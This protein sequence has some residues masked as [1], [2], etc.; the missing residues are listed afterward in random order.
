MHSKAHW[1]YNTPLAH[2][3]LHNEKIDENSIPS[4]EN[5]IINN[6]GIELDV[7]VTLD[8]KVV[9]I[10]DVNT[11][12]TTGIDLNVTKTTYEE[13]AKLSL[14][15]TKTK[16]PLL[17]D[18]LQLVAGQV[19]LLIE[20]KAENKVPANLISTVLETL[21]DY[22]YPETIALQSFNPYVVRDL[23]ALQKKFMVGQLMS[24]DLPNQTKF[25]H[26]LYRSLLVLSVSKP[27]FINYDI[28]YIN[29]PKLQKKREKLPLLAWTIDTDEKRLIAN[30]FAD[31]IIFEKIK[32]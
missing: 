26:F 18:V 12:R 28:K 31:N 2:R 14:L 6:F 24:D 11:L 8:N 16:I 4:F 22:K 1:L 25:V 27:D 21:T 7:H 29:K 32:I 17:T 10:H 23:K 3:G 15:I 5:A 19:P 13:L 30:K 9:V 20:L